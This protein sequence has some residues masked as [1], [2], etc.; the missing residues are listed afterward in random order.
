MSTTYILLNSADPSVLHGSS[1]GDFTVQLGRSHTFAED[2]EVFLSE[3]VIPFTW[4]NVTSEN[5]SLVVSNTAG[6]KTITLPPAY[7]ESI[8]VLCKAINDALKAA[9]LSSVKIT[10]DERTMK[11]TID[12]GTST[13]RG[14]L[15]LLLGWPKI[16]VHGRVT[17]PKMADITEGDSSLY[18]LVDCI[19]STT[20]GSF[21]IPLLKKLEVGREDRPG[22]LIHYCAHN[23]VEAHQLSQKI[24]MH[25]GVTIKDSRNRIVQFN[26]FN[27]NLTLGIRPMRQ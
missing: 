12:T 15:M 1:P 2:S 16:T 10:A 13:V 17:A 6:S 4:H 20:A 14:P 7:Y 19:E 9:S 25:I 23:P 24:L 27:V 18:V 3:A 11:V 21:S 26:G 5:G 8:P 22:D